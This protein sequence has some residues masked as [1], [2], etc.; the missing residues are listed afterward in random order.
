MRGFEFRVLGMKKILLRMLLLEWAL[1]C[2]FRLVEV[3]MKI[4][5]EN[6]EKKKKEN[7]GIEETNKQKEAIIGNGM[8]C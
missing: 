6:F 4:P 2:T 5:D 1:Q 8:A 7:K 3:S